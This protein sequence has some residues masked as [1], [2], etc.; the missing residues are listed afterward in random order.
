MEKVTVKG[1]TAYTSQE[2]RDRLKSIISR[3]GGPLK[4][5]FN[6]F[7]DEKS[8]VPIVLESNIF[9]KLIKIIKPH[10]LY[11]VYGEFIGNTMYIVMSHK[12][13]I[14]LRIYKTIVHEYI[15]YVMHNYNKHFVSV[16][17]DVI[18]KFYELF[19]IEY[20]VSNSY[21]KD[22]FSKFIDK[23]NDQDLKGNLV[24]RNYRL[25]ELSFKKY[26]VLDKNEFEKKITD[27]LDYMD[28][29]YSDIYANSSYPEIPYLIKYCYTKIFGR[30]DPPTGYGQETYY[31]SEIISVLSMIKPRHPLV[32]KTLEILIK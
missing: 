16:N 18:F 29:T 31:P 30:H 15:H 19:Y 1:L 7:V 23:I 4:E 32:K 21:D 25:I 28:K 6:K 9:Q 22:L 13:I 24:P 14:D 26:T 2:L 5:I 11:G 10:K 3:Y 27:L 8:L 20:L 17:K 12:N